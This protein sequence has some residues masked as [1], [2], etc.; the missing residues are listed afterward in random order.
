MQKLVTSFIGLF[1]DLIS[2]LLW[3]E[4]GIHILLSIFANTRHSCLSCKTLFFVNCIQTSLN[5]TQAFFVSHLGKHHYHH[6]LATI[7]V[8]NLIIAIVSLDTLIKFVL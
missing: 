1:S 5:V 6:L 3:Q 7:K 2:L 8:L 4:R